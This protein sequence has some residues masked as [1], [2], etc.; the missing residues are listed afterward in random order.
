[1]VV[2]PALALGF[3]GAALSG[4][5][6]KSLGVFDIT[7]GIFSNGV[8]ITGDAHQA[9]IAQD[10]FRQDLRHELSLLIRED[11]RDV[12]ALMSETISTQVTMGS[13][14][15]GV[16]FAVLIEGYL[17][18]A[19]SIWMIE[20]WGM[21]TAW[22]AFLT[23]CSLMLATY[24]QTFI[25]KAASKQLITKHRIATPNDV[26]IS[27]LGGS[28][29]A[30]RVGRLH[31]L[32]VDQGFSLAAKAEQVAN[33]HLFNE[34]KPERK[35]S[36]LS[37]QSR[38]SKPVTRAK[39]RKRD[40]HPDLAVECVSD[41][42]IVYGDATEARRVIRAGRDVHAWF[43][44]ADDEEAVGDDGLPERRVVASQ[45][46]IDLPNFLDGCALVRQAWRTMT[47]AD[48]PSLHLRIQGEATLYIAAQA[49]TISPHRPE[50]HQDGNST[51]SLV[52]EQEGQQQQPQLQSW[53][54][55]LQL[56]DAL[57]EWEPEERPLLLKGKHPGPFEFER[58]NGFTVLIDECKT[59]LP[60]YKVPLASPMEDDGC[61]DVVIQWCF[62][63][64]VDGLTVIIREGCVVTAE[65]EWPQRAF[66]DQITVMEPHLRFADW[67][68]RSGISCLIGAVL[69][70]H[71][72]RI[73]LYRAWPFCAAEVVCVSVAVVVA[74][75]A[76][77][78]FRRTPAK[79]FKQRHADNRPPANEDG[80]DGCG[81]TS[82][83]LF[84]AHNQRN[85][86][87]AD[88]IPGESSSTQQDG[89][90]ASSAMMRAMEKSKLRFFIAKLMLVSLLFLSLIACLKTFVGRGC[91]MGSAVWSFHSIVWPPLFLPAAVTFASSG[92]LLAV[93]DRLLVVL[94][95]DSSHSPAVRLANTVLGLGTFT[96]ATGT[97]TLVAVG[98]D[99]QIRLL[100]PWVIRSPMAVEAPAPALL[101]TCLA[102]GGRSSAEASGGVLSLPEAADGELRGP[103]GLTTARGALGV[104]L[105]EADGAVSLY[106]AMDLGQSS[107]RLVFLSRVAR[108]RLHTTS[109]AELRALHFRPA[110]AHAYAGTLLAH[111]SD[112][113]FA[114]V[115]LVSGDRVHVESPCPASCC[116][117]ASLT[118]NESHLIAV[119]L[120]GRGSEP[121]ARIAPYD[122]LLGGVQPWQA[123]F[124]W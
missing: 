73:M 117:V 54:E 41:E 8:T 16:C 100:E 66:L 86:A 15:L 21:L 98:Q 46:L 113:V 9:Q 18:D 96:D 77:W 64:Q 108:P 17:D 39:T 104:A 32:A 10:I 87:A 12:H 119:C 62:K 88:L 122:L 90:M 26:V 50:D 19:P 13:I 78:S 6:K 69:V 84:K 65:D 109:S 106:A 43:V 29:L 114:A 48:R 91:Y 63:G 110:G 35:R 11:M 40:R 57:H 74:L 107:A 58:V 49:Q 30:E 82:L 7:N 97:V 75:I 44:P 76:T 45:K 33:D 28:H 56:Q 34:D 116:T 80:Q 89:S 31:V 47:D 120:G 93:S 53:T 118:G 101:L 71:I 124:G 5:F 112:G 85:I 51:V 95:N 70:M 22:S 99:G 42:E 25:S 3:V 59:F 68:M 27:R 67:S 14:I 1:M 111:Y 94:G 72:S 52:N 102:V 81:S 23:F 123:F 105:G 115:N 24:F 121:V 61:V 103:I 37:L 2:F 55:A 38:A 20:V 92:D 83:E 79:L 4:A 36:S 60:L